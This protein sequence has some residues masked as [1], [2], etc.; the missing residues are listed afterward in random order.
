[1]SKSDTIGVEKEIGNQVRLYIYS[2]P[3]K[4]H[5][6]M[7]KICSQFIEMFR[8]HGVMPGVFSLIE[9]RPPKALLV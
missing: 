1:M 5:D 2:V 3:K 9:P 4:N 7:L 8:R 6:A